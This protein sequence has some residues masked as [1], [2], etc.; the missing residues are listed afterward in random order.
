MTQNIPDRDSAMALLKKYNKTD[1]MI[2]HALSVE[3]VMRHFS[4]RFNGDEEKWGIIGL[5]HD[6]DYEMYPEEHCTKTR[7]ILEE[8][9]WPEEYIRAV[10]SH[11]WGICSDVEPLSDLEKVLYAGDELS[12]LVSATALV[13][14]SKSIMDLTAK[15]VKKK[16]KDKSFSAGVDRSIIEKG[17]EMLNIE[18]TELI[19]ETIKG[20]QKVARDIGLEGITEQA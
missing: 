9:N 18:I 2:K 3:A 1:R 14:P 17:A 19:T 11:G 6:L 16:W 13:R 15:S 20:M 4:K 7:E 8:N 12:G 5:V 10:V